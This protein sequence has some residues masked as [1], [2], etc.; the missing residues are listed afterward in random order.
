[1]SLQMSTEPAELGRLLFS[2]SSFRTMDFISRRP[3][4]SLDFRT[5]S[6]MCE[7]VS[8]G[9]LEVSGETR[10]STGL[11]PI[12]SPWSRRTVEITF[13]S[14]SSPFQGTASKYSKHDWIHELKFRNSATCSIVSY[15][16]SGNVVSSS[17]I[18]GSFSMK[19]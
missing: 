6:T 3:L 9:A 17:T 1:M 15:Y 19:G 7:R 8:F 5:S 18:H 10:F 16:K 14:S 12:P 2:L 4:S 13:S 11:T